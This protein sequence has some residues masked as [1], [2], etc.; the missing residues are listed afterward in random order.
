MKPFISVVI[1]TYNRK[2][3]VE[4]C[5]KHLLNQTYPSDRYEIIIIDD[6]ST[7]GT[8]ELVIRIAATAPTRILYSFF[9]TNKGPAMARNTGIKKSSGEII[10]F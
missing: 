1:P 8:R 6:G 5:L 9:Q 7:D 4:R 10:L 2:E 3:I